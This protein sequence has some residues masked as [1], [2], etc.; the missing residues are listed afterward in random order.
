[1]APRLGHVHHTGVPKF[2][3]GARV[4]KCFGNF[5]FFLCTYLFVALVWL[6]LVCWVV[7]DPKFVNNSRRAN[8]CKYLLILID[9]PRILYFDVWGVDVECVSFSLC[10]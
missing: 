7:E 6:A 1:M 3:L 9:M 8:S 5:L 2:G 4:G 10:T